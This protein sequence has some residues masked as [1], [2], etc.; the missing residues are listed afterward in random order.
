[1]LSRDRRLSVQA[2]VRPADVKRTAARGR[3]QKVAR[4]ANTRERSE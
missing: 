3:S 1:M 4:K 2:D